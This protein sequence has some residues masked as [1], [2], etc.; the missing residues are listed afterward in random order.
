MHAGIWCIFH[1]SVLE[2]N[3]DVLQKLLGNILLLRKNAGKIFTESCN[4]LVKF[5]YPF[6]V[7]GKQNY[8]EK[9]NELFL[10]CD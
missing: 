4:N 10:L 3:I 8:N 7:S 5:N 6:G 9:L 2:N 1:T